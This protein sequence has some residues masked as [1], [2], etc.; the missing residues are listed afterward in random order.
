[1]NQWLRNIVAGLVAI[2]PVYPLAQGAAPASS[3][4]TAE[5]A[6]NPIPAGSVAGP[7]QSWDKAQLQALWD[8]ARHTAGTTSYE[9]KWIFSTDIRTARVARLS[10][11]RNAKVLRAENLIDLQPELRGRLSDLYQPGQSTEPF[12]YTQRGAQ[13]W[14]VLQL[15][16]RSAAPP[17]RSGPAFEASARRWVKFGLLPPPE[18]LLAD[19]LE[20]ARVAYWNATSAAAV[21]VIPAELTPNV[22]FG[23]HH[24]PL[25]LAIISKKRDLAQALI[26]HGADVKQCGL[27][28][29]PLGIVAALDDATQALD[30]T[31]WLLARGAA[32]D[33][34]DT[35]Y[36]LGRSTALS[37]A[38]TRGWK[39]VGEALLAAGAS[40]DGAP[41][42]RMT[43]IESAAAYKHRDMVEWLIA[44][45]ASVL[46][47][48]D[49]GTVTAGQ[50]GN[51]Y[52]AA[53]STGDT[54]FAEWAESTMLSAAQKSPRLRFDAFIEQD[55]QRLALADDTKLSLRA[56]PFKLVLVLRPGEADDVMLGAS[57][58]PAWMDEVRHGDRRNPLF[59]PFAAAAL[60]ATPE[61]GSY[62]L[63]VGQPCPST[64]K[65][66]GICPGVQ[67]HL[68]TDASA[69]KDFHE[70]RASRNEY[71]REYRSVAD[72]SAD[73][74]SPAQP[75][76]EFAGQTLQLV[77]TSELV[78]G[79][80]ERKVHLIGPRYVT[81]QLQK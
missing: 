16:S 67:W 46:P 33:G 31:Q 61:P 24:T 6:N 15:V 10:G 60:A 71:V 29:C 27:G 57:F 58:D 8:T 48:P 17:L 18:V 5:S 76:Q 43:P 73:K 39:A 65:P 77:L 1:M 72:I 53:A 11:L 34:I 59:E 63:L 66:D 19:P 55:K 22:Q 78:L 49:R 41:D 50:R 47:L 64:A 36:L 25:T 79:G 52:L 45:G 37:A 21:A 7:D 44:H 30:W 12:A 56:A 38:M 70:I 75:L 13:G 14:S 28:G 62:E 2:V 81:L 35:R 32:P 4:A 42:V 20:R 9:Y 69:R 40:P 51:L 74:A 3:G 23:N 54:A 80:P 68:Q 26:D